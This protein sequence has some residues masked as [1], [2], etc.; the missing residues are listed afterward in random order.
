[1]DVGITQTQGNINADQPDVGI[2][3]DIATGGVS[4]LGGTAAFEDFVT[5]Q[6]AANCT[7]TVTDKSTESTAGGAMLLEASAAHTVH[8]NAADNWAASGDSAAI[9]SGNVTI[10][11]R[12]LGA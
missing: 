11:W 4:V 6:A 9:L 8:F 12:F 10:A 1:M 3:T 5:G 2:G 7:G